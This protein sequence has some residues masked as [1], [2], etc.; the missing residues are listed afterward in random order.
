MATIQSA[1]IGSGLDVNSIVSK[2][3]AIESQPLLDIAKKQASY[4][5]NLTAFGSLSG[6]LSALQTSLSGLNSLSTYKTLNATS[7]DTTVATAT[8]S[9]I[10]TAGTYS[11]N[12]TQLAQAQTI[13]SAG[14]VSTTNTIGTGAATTLS[15]QFGTI[16]GT[17][18][19]GTYTGATFQQDATQATGTVTINSSNNSLQGIRDAINNANVGVQASIVGDGSATPYHLVLNSTKTGVTSSMKISVTGDATLQNLLAYDPAGVQNLKELKN[20]QNA[21]LTLNGLAV[22]STSNTVSNAIQGVSVNLSKIGTAS[23]TLAANTAA[24]QSGI[25][26]FVTAYNSLNTTLTTLTAYNPA[27]KVGGPLL[28]DST[29]QSIQNQI[30]NALSG[31]VNGL[32][33]GLINLEQVGVTFQ[34][35]GT[36]SVDSTKLQNA[37]NTNFG[38]VAGLFAAAGKATDSLVSFVGSTTKTT[39]GNYAVNVTQ[40]ATQ[41][42]LTGNQNLNAAPVTI[43]AGTSINV[44]LDGTTAAVNLT[45]GT[46]TASAL[47]SLIQSSINGNTTLSGLGLSVTAS[48]D[49]SGFLNLQSAS[50]GSNSSVSIANNTGTTISN[51]TGTV[52]SG[53]NGK[54]VAGTING[55]GATGIGQILTGATGTGVEGLQILVNGGATGARGNINFSQGYAYKLNTAITGFL[56]TS[57]AINNATDGINS[58]LKDLQNQTTVINQRLVTKQA[59]Y[60]R[61]FSALDTVIANLNSTQSFLTQQINVLNGL[62]N[63]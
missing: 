47:A 17:A 43:A 6:A 56:G 10:A 36:L 54:N 55:I 8:G 29:T 9:S 28:G 13:S 51:F 35:D 60:Q 45:A 57:G 62:S 58:T 1:G 34:K 26:G 23:I 5:A 4:Q 27:T 59:L 46:Y 3:M 33:G 30:R 22:T 49:A 31:A 61:Q 48:I 19:N 20:G 7:S 12:V 53:V 42:L 52:T 41:G 2:L 40:V 14:Q 37:L 24:V 63:K 50:Y 44:T 38:D 21:S 39:A 18:T 25:N 11:L 15:F 16:T 32:G